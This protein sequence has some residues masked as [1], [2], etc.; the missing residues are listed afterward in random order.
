MGNG[1]ISLPAQDLEAEERQTLSTMMLATTSARKVPLLKLDAGRIYGGLVGQSEANLRNVI[2][3]AEAIAPCCLRLDEAEIHL[4]DRGKNGGVLA[5][6]DCA[7][8]RVAGF[9]FRDRFGRAP[10]RHEQHP[11][12]RSKSSLSPKPSGSSGKSSCPRL[13]SIEQ[14]CAKKQRVFLYLKCK[15]QGGS[16]K[17]LKGRTSSRIQT[18]CLVG[19]AVLCAPGTSHDPSESSRFIFTWR[20]GDRCRALYECRSLSLW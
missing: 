14:R 1:S 5:G 7:G 11:L 16:S 19:R 15:R 17:Q 9:P 18:G 13:A 6:E 8:E 12:W 3:T 20:Y 2:Q 4:G 10:V